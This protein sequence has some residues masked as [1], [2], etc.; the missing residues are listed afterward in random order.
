MQYLLPVTRWHF[1]ETLLNYARD[2]EQI[3][4]TPL[5]SHC[6]YEKVYCR[7]MGRLARRHHEG[8]KTY[9]WC[10]TTVAQLEILEYITHPTRMLPKTL[11]G[12]LQILAVMAGPSESLTYF[13]PMMR[14]ATRL[15]PVYIERRCDGS[16]GDEHYIVRIAHIDLAIPRTF[17][18]AWLDVI[19]G[20][21]LIADPPPY[22]MRCIDDCMIDMSRWHIWH[23]EDRIPHD[24]RKFMNG[25]RYLEQ[26]V[27]WHDVRNGTHL[28]QYLGATRT[29]ALWFEGMS[30]E[31]EDVYL[32]NSTIPEASS[33][34]VHAGPGTTL[35]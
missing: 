22:R 5:Q 25:A 21:K 20:C 6:I 30:P 12:V 8:Q 15:G 16:L 14:Q 9:D 27:C 24:L 11:H 17:H 19:N 29:A 13:P 34:I 4:L 7:G 28:A 26:V 32:F 2:T 23:M 3:E 33:M 31:A 10:N 1:Y 18:S 35:F